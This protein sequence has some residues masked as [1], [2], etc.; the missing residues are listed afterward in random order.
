[1]TSDPG[2]PHYLQKE[3]ELS[4]GRVQFGREEAEL[5]SDGLWPSLTPDYSPGY[6][7]SCDRT[8]Q[9]IVTFVTIN[10]PQC[11][12]A[13]MPECL[14]VL[15]SAGAP[16]SEE[17]AAGSSRHR[18]GYGRHGREANVTGGSGLEKRLEE[19]EKD[20][21]DIEDEN[22]QLKQENK[23]LLKVVGQLTR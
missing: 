22:E 5:S 15:C 12:M 18:L 17:E 10:A 7:K 1:M 21:D 13:V 23:T 14:R 20:L 8:V 4:F 19:L 9:K 16:G 6:T 3:T 11:V 2:M